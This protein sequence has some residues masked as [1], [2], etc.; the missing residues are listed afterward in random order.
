MQKWSIT[1]SALVLVACGAKEPVPE[2]KGEMQ[3][4]LASSS[5]SSGGRFK[6]TLG[7]AVYDLEVGCTGLDQDYFSFLSDKNDVTDSNGDG[8]VISGMQ[9]GKNLIL[10]IINQ[11]D[12][13]SAPSLAEWKKSSSG[14]TGSGQ[15]YLKSDSSL[16]EV[17]FEVT[18]P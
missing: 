11:D 17:V 14:A 18:C 12:S 9:I 13:W 3:P 15:V 6:A 7:D 8:L 1:L 5:D 10:T 16:H 2:K 4:S